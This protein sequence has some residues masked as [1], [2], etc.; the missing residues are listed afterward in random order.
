[1]EWPM[2]GQN[3]SN[4]RH[5][6]NEQHLSSANVGRLRP[7]WI[8]TTGGDV[9]AT[10]A[11]ADGAVYTPD[12]KGNVF[13]IDAVSGKLQWSR[14]VEDYTSIAR[15][16]A[17]T[18]PAV[19]GGAL[20]LGTVEGAFMLALRTD[21]G[22]LIWKTQLDTH[23]F[24][25]IIQSAV[26]YQDRI[27]V[28]V[29]S[30]EELY[31]LGTEG[32]RCCT[33]RGSVVALDARTGDIVWRTYMTL[34]NNGR[35]D[36]FSGVAVWGSTPVVDAAR[37]TLYVTTGN[38]YNVPEEVKACQKKRLT[39]PK[40]PSCAVPGNHI[41][42]VVALNLD[43]G[44]VK[45]STSI[46]GYDAWN[47]TCFIQPSNKNCPDPFGGD[48]DFAQGAMLF[49]VDH[50]GGFQELLGV[51]QKSGFFWALDPET[52]TIQWSTKVG[53]S[54]NLGGMMW[55]SATD[56]RRIYVALSNSK[57]E[58]FRLQPSGVLSIGGAWSALDAATGKILWQ[59]ATPGSA[60]AMG[61]VTVANGVLYAPSM[62]LAGDNMF[63]LDA[64]S[65]K[66]LWR[67]P[68]GGSVLSGAAVVNGVVYWGSGYANKLQG[69][70]NN[71]LFA[72]SLDR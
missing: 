19:A 44:L 59:T 3:L 38:N 50:N 57:A 65:G 41:D 8:F 10:P 15:S 55:G 7:K 29:S 56:G 48:F 39:D 58:R 46:E 63:A 4:T 1:M 70:P 26:V 6:P 60:A 21:T 47:A 33:F 5:Q 67:Y 28:G 45:W 9:S 23:P 51:G 61:P 69:R 36:G 43:T 53:P 24:A 14:R 12:W 30:L 64:A 49:R 16:V 11:V 27:Y 17:R 72:F 22:D 20:Y 52:G 68:S 31:L 54:G 13:K 34:D 66:I 35:T 42:A 62:A 2:G 37:N 71:K 32:Y 18:T 25:N 40:L